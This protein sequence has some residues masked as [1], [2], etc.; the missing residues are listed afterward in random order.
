[1]ID[2]TPLIALLHFVE[3]HGTGDSPTP[4]ANGWPPD[5]WDTYLRQM[6]IHLHRRASTAI[7]QSLPRDADGSLG[8]ADPTPDPGNP[9]S[10]LYI[11]ACQLSSWRTAPAFVADARDNFAILVD[12]D[13]TLRHVAAVA[14]DRYLARLCPIPPHLRQFARDRGNLPSGIKAQPVYTFA[15]T[16]DYDRVTAGEQV[17]CPIRGQHLGQTLDTILAT[18]PDYLIHLATD[19]KLALQHGSFADAFRTFY[20][21]PATQAE[22][23]LHQATQGTTP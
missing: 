2:P 10:T 20:N 7:A 14:L 19:A 3:Q 23:R 22:L 15:P 1:M 9:T 17:K 12:L 18:D 11:A 16:G 8:T 5:H 21:H 6:L 4:Q 13:H